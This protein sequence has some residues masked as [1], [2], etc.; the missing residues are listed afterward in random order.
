MNLRE[1]TTRQTG[2]ITSWTVVEQSAAVSDSNTV[3][4]EGVREC[5]VYAHR[6]PRKWGYFTIELQP[7]NLTRRYVT[8]ESRRVGAGESV[9][10]PLDIGDPLIVE[11]NVEYRR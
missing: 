2:D 4:I 9:D 5:A 8:G 1:H 3:G 7:S 11:R 10:H 6:Q